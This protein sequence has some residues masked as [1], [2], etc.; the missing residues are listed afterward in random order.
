M[1][2]TRLRGL[3]D[4]L[5]ASEKKFFLG[6]DVDFVLIIERIRRVAIA[7]HYISALL[8]NA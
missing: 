8:L 4:R 5:V 1:K 2:K 3:Q 6:C 7:D